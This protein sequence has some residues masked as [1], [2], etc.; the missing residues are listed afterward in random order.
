MIDSTAG[1]LRRIKDATDEEKFRKLAAEL[2][3]ASAVY[4]EAVLLRKS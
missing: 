4:G 3:E 1:I 2:L